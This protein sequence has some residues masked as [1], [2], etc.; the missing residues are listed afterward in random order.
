MAVIW[1]YHYK[2]TKYT[3]VY[4]TNCLKEVPKNIKFKITTFTKN[5]QE[6]K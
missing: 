3:N 4:K 5:I 1:Q 6:L 2:L